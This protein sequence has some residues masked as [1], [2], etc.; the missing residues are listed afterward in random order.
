M[1]QL[2]P[3]AIRSFFFRYLGLFLVGMAIISAFGSVIVK[4]ITGSPKIWVWVLITIGGAALCY[5][6]ALLT[7]RN[8]RYGFTDEGIEIKKG[9]VRKR[10]DTIPYTKIQNVDVKQDLLSRML[11]LG[12]VVIQTAGSSSGWSNYSGLSKVIKFLASSHGEP[13]KKE[14][15]GIIPGLNIK[16]AREFQETLTGGI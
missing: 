12:K 15:E 13:P 16:K 3:K 4:N 2:H 10:Y 9:V 8:W 5:A 7:Y 1:N 11:D 6:W 14:G